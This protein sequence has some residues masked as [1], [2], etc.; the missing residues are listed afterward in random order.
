[1]P[2]ATGHNGRVS[3]VPASSLIDHPRA[4]RAGRVALLLLLVVISWLALRTGP[5]PEISTGTDKLDHMAAFAALAATAVLGWRRPLAAAL[6]LVGY[7]VL[8]ELLQSQIPGRTAEVADVL[9]DAI[10]IGV[11]LAVFA[12]AARIASRR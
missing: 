3:P 8:I 11:G 1:M 5:G 6:A 9:A 7:G 4:T 12:L 2:Q 10:G